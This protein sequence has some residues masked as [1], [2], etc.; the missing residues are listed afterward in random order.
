MLLRGPGDLGRGFRRGGIGLAR[1]VPRVRAKYRVV[2][3]VGGRV[4]SVAGGADMVSAALHTSA[5]M[6]WKTPMEVWSLVGRLAAPWPYADPCPP[7]ED[8][9]WNHEDDR[10]CDGLRD[11]WTPGPLHYVNPPYGREL[12]K[13]IEAC[14][15][16]W[17]RG[18]EVL[19]LV[20]A[21]PDTK[22][23]HK[24][25][26]SVSAIVWWKG[27]L[28]FEGAK[29]AA[30]FPSAFLYWGQRTRKLEVVF[31]PYGRVEVYR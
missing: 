7:P 12:P 2:R 20:P 19:A 10:P 28:K 26:G 9:E 27:R 31:G 13:W 5:R 30:P 15:K 11:P 24:A 8:R 29:H 16:N 3:V 4:R 1:G 23:F 18:C 25:W 17:L 6:D 22:W 14:E 21:R